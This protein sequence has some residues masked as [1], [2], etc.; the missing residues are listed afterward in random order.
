M[1]LDPVFASWHCSSH[2]GVSMRGAQMHLF[3]LLESVSRWNPSRVV[4]LE[5]RS[6]RLNPIFAKNTHTPQRS[7]VSS[8]FPPPPKFSIY[9]NWTAVVVAV[10]AVP[11]FS[12][13]NRRRPHTIEHLS[14]F[15]HSPIPQFLIP[16]FPNSPKT[17]GPR[18]WWRPRSPHW[19]C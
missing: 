19:C 1:V 8:P 15:P 13:I 14:N 17:T 7:P 4:L 12:R 9:L 11:L 3:V 10:V 6:A 2:S 16:Q 18:W 5:M